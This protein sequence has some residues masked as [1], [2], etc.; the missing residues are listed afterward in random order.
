MINIAL[1]DNNTVFGG[2]SGS[3]DPLAIDNDSDGLINGLDLISDG[4]GIFD[5]HKVGFN[6]ALVDPDNDGMVNGT[7]T[8]D[9]GII[10]GAPANIDNNSI[11]GGNFGRIVVT[12]AIYEDAGVTRVGSNVPITLSV[13]GQEIGTG[14]TDAN[15]EYS[16]MSAA[17]FVN[18]DV[19]TLFI[20]DASFRGVT[21]FAGSQNSVQNG[22]SVLS[23]ADVYNNMLITR[24]GN[25]TEVNNSHLAIA[26]STP[27]P[28]IT[29]VFDIGAADSLTVL[30]GNDLYIW[31]GVKTQITGNSDI[32][33]SI[34]NNSGSELYI[35]S[36][37]ILRVKF[38]IINEENSYLEIFS[39]ATVEVGN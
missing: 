18:T 30:S 35:S 15:G 17:G 36:G 19:L 21:V 9:D 20:N 10:N 1:L 26:E 27:N 23:G 39:G 16:I 33:G 13:N 8:D 32:K 29:A 37:V 14:N 12:G 28:A 7:D 34:Y 3:Q 38:D 31:S 5:L 11:F 4:D 24:S 6:I 22:G 2:A 25:G